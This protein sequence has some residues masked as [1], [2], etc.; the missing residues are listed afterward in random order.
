MNEHKNKRFKEMYYEDAVQKFLDL[1]NIKNYSCYFQNGNSPIVLVDVN[2]DVDLSNKKLSNQDLSKIH[3]KFRKVTGN[4]NCSNNQL[5]NLDFAPEF[6]GGNFD[7]SD[8][9]LTYLDGA[10]NWVKGD[11]ECSDNKLLT[12]LGNQ[13]LYVGG[14]FYCLNNNKLQSL[15]RQAPTNIKGKMMFHLE[16]LAKLEIMNDLSIGNFYI[17]HARDLAFK[18]TTV[19]NNDN[20]C[21]RTEYNKIRSELFL[22][23]VKQQQLPQYLYKYCSLEKLRDQNPEDEINSHTKSILTANELYFSCPTKFNDPYDCNPPINSN[24]TEEEIKDWLNLMRFSEEFLPTVK[25]LLENDPD[26][27][28]RTAL[29]KIN[30]IGICCFSTLENSILM[31][32]HYADYHKGIC[33]TFDINQDPDFFLT[34]CIVHYAQILPHFNY[35]NNNSKEITKLIRTKFTDWSYES[36]VRILK[37]NAEIQNNKNSAN[38][39]IFKFKNE[40]LI[41]I[42]FGTNTSEEDIKIIKKL[43]EK[44]G[45]NHVKFSKMKLKEGI[46]YG[47]EKVDL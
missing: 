28:K 37:S 22:K 8:N 26:F 19:G 15:T 23:L 44:S 5:T 21:P 29:E 24:A 13:S 43:C 27:I 12:S 46:H 16:D 38:P 41:E 30:N 10:P 20:I 33:L 11:F 7:C 4:F 18:R 47:L 36:E 25:N 42:I 6:V 2:G 32:S 40:A 1:N 9:N 31:W 3:L 17:K 39:R 35:F 34:P 14:D 45:K